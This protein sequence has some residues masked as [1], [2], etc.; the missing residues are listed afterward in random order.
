MKPILA[1]LVLVLPSCMARRDANGWTLT[2]DI[3]TA[4]KAI[5]VMNQK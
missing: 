4:A 5:R 3:A 2:F 1:A